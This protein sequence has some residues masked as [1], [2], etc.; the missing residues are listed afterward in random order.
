MSSAAAFPVAIVA[1]LDAMLWLLL[2]DGFVLP[3]HLREGVHYSMT[4]VPLS[5]RD[6]RE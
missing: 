1:V 6:V 3:V 5:F 4:F 2:L